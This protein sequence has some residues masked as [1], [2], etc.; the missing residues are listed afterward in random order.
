MSVAVSSDNGGQVPIGGNLEDFVVQVYAT[1]VHWT[2]AETCINT[3]L[4]IL[5]ASS[6]L[7][8]RRTAVAKALPNFDRTR[9][10][11]ALWVIA[12]RREGFPIRTAGE[13]NVSSRFNAG[14]NK[15]LVE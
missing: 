14:K 15:W 11:F 10:F 2:Q 7:D 8:G 6:R 4:H 12:T 13:G 1:D 9:E 5:K 3:E